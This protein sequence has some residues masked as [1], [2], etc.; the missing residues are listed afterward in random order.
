MLELEA[1]GHVGDV[2]SIAFALNRERAAVVEDEPNAAA[3]GCAEAAREFPGADSEP[4]RLDEFM[5]GHRG[6]FFGG[7]G[8]PVPMIASVANADGG[9]S[10]LGVG[11]VVKG[12]GCC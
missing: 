7:G 11:S 3:H 4:D 5:I 1:G 9:G 10:F 2:P 8:P 6:G 12:D